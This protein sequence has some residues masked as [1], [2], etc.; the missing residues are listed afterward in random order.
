M[1]PRFSAYFALVL[2]V[3]MLAM[4]Q[5]AAASN[6]E[7]TFGVKTGYVS[8][9]QSALAGLF[10][11][12]SFTEHFRI[13][14][15][16]SIA[17]RNNNRDGI[18][19]DVN[20]HIPLAQSGIAQIYPLAGLNYS[21]WSKHTT[22]VDKIAGKDVTSRTSRFGLNLGGGMGLKLS[23]TL[24]VK[25]EAGYTLLKSN[26]AFRATIGIGYNF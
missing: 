6:H 16:A 9:N 10:F 25:V 7:K 5:K 12:Y 8:R 3:M 18:L 23:S 22:P 4:P 15:E 19:F 26:N 24:T 13:A 11:Q 20:C 1:R 2:A 14:P 17:F 21:S